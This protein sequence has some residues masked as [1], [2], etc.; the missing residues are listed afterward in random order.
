MADRDDWAPYSRSAGR[1]KIGPEVWA[2][3]PADHVAALDAIAAARGLRRP[4]VV[5]EA[6]A[7]YIRHAAPAQ[8]SP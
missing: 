3:V 2:A 8:V 5:R 4:D 1:P 7:E 6:I